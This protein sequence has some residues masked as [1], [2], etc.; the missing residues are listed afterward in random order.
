MLLL[1]QP[2]E[3]KLLEQAEQQLE[4]PL[5]PM[6]ARRLEMQQ[7][8]LTGQ[9]FIL[10]FVVVVALVEETMLMVLEVEAVVYTKQELVLQLL[11]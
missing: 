10:L 7:Y 9:Q 2:G 1:Y 5:E 4:L 8:Q 3:L 6:V 11:L